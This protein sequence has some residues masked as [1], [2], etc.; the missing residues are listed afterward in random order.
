MFTVL[1]VLSFLPESHAESLAF[2]GAEGFGATASGGR[3]GAVCHVT[4]LDDSGAGSLRD[5]VSQPHRIVVFDVGGIINLKLHLTFA[6]HLT[7]AGQTASGDGITVSGQD[8]SFSNQQNVIVR[9][10]RFRSSHLTSNGTKTLNVTGGSNMIFDHC[11]ISWGRW[12]NVGFTSGA[13]DITLQ[14]SIVSEAINPQ[15]FGA[16]I[17][18]APIVSRLSVTCGSTIRV[19][20]PKAKPICSLSITRFTTGAATATSAAIP[21]Q[22]GTKI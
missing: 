9:Y 7:V 22:F 11:S 1:L 15:R 10:L 20:T 18:T 5:A 8:I 4:N 13:H 21:A 19:A 3:G 14:N 6:S 17:D 12:D 2:P 16:L